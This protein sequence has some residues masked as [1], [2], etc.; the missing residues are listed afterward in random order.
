M[1]VRV[2]GSALVLA[3]VGLFAS[4]CAKKPRDATPEGAVESFLHELDEAPRDPT[5]AARAYALLAEDAR[6]ALRLRAERARSLTGQR[7]TPEGM[8]APLWS[9]LR[10]EVDR[11]T[12][13]PGKDAT[14]ALVD[15]FG[16]DPGAQHATVPVVHEASGWRIV[17]SIPPPPPPDVAP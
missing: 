17:L 5:A 14:H 9:T 4:S 10:F 13:K 11:V 2:G 12:S 16:V 8:L 1:R 15:V 6:E 7:A 3:L